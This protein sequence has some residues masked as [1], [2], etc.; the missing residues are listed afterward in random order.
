MNYSKSLSNIPEERLIRVGVTGAT[1]SDPTRRAG[2]GVTVT[3]TAAGVLKYAFADNPGTFVAIS[4]PCL[5]ADTPSGVKGY[6][7]SGDTYIAPASGAD[8]YI[9]VSI[10]DASNNAVDLTTVQYL[11]LTFVFAAQSEIT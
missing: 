10:W 1:T 11:D 3:R 7:I 8:G 4:G 5:R 2:P 6:S 9:E